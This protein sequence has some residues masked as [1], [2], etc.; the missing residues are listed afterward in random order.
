[1]LKILH[2]IA[3]LVALL[4]IA[5]FFIATIIVELWGSHQ[6]IAAVKSFIVMPGLFILIP[7]IAL[8]GG[9]GFALS[10]SRQGKLVTVKKRR[11]PF[12]AMNGLLILLPA[13]LYLNHLAALGTFDTLFYTIQT[14][15]LLGGAINLTLMSLNIRD[16]LRLGGYFRS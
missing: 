3:G 9:T 13:A 5:T 16:G 1:M 12:I 11:M 4:T 6:M 2:L 15:E 14:V 7:A 10:K 8:T